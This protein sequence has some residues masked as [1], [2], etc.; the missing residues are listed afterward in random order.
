MSDP[1]LLA[2]GGFVLDRARQRVVHGDGSPVILTPRLFSA[3]LLFVERAGELLDK[4]S[5]MAALWPGLVV[6]ENNLNQVVHALRRVLGDDGSRFI[7][8]VPRRGFR[9]VAA[10]TVLPDA[11][12][13]RDELP[14]PRNVLAA[15][16]APVHDAVLAAT[17]V[18]PPATAGVP[19][20]G[21][22]SRGWNWA[23]AT[24][25]L[26]AVGGTLLAL[27]LFWA[28]APVS[29]DAELADRRSIAVMPFT[30]LSDPKAPHVAYA[31]DHEL[32]N[33][34]GR[35]PHIRVVS[36]ESSAVLG[37]SA[38]LDPRQVGRE[39]GVKHVLAGTVRQEGESLSVTIRLLRTDTGALLWSDRFDYLSVADWAAQQNMLA[40]VGNLL[41]AK[42]QQSVL[43]QAM[44]SPPST[45]AVDH[46]MRGTYVMTSMT[47]REQLALAR[48]HFEAALAA[49]PNS[50]PALGGLASTHVREVQRR[51]SVD[52]ALSLTT[53]K[54]LARRAVDENPDDQMALMVLGAAQNFSGEVDDALTTTQRVL[55]LNPNNA[56]ANRQLA[57]CFFFLGRWE[58][59]LRQV[60]VAE[61]LNPLDTDNMSKLHD[62]AATALVALHRYDEAIERARRGAATNPSNL[63]PLIVLASAEAHRDN[64]AAARQH[65]A[66]ILKRQPGYWVGRDR[67]SRGS[68]APAY[69]AAVDH[70]GEGLKLAGIPASPPSSNEASNGSR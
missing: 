1:G 38:T 34:L 60:D 55:Q 47:T 17:S 62:T 21:R 13:G 46:W 36:R 39:L 40:S 35:L 70:M 66:E 24:L 65:A 58:D 31:V 29:I 16:P 19:P 10:V 42:V 3:L 41:D 27:T 7:E 56:A 43:E 5:M 49:Q 30:D 20:T 6:E 14:S 25:A 15:V 9:F 11:P 26:A 54:T 44:L 57:I 53:A 37:T 68:T 28:S 18:L 22:R 51:W 4:E 64:L 2:F 12:G 50:V 48:R 52:P 67:A 45:A 69:R 61:R 33:G 23:A 59:A 63:V 8:T 32:T